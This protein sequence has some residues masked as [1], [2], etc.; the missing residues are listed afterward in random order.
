[1]SH[2]QTEAPFVGDALCLA[3]CEWAVEVEVGPSEGYM[4][5]FGFG[6]IL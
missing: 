5:G 1:M 6:V 3:L 2:T 4:G